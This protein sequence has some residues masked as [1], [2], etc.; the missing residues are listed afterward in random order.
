VFNIVVVVQP[1]PQQIKSVQREIEVVTGSAPP[2]MLW[3]SASDKEAIV[4]FFSSSF[5][6][7]MN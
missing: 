3:L 6:F 7:F 4:F 2:I 5:F 1:S